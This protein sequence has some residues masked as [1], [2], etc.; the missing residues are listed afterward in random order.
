MS[1]ELAEYRERRR[2]FADCIGAAGMDAAIV[3]SRG[4][5]TLDRFANVLYLTGH[6]QSYA[7]LPETPGLFSGR[8]H[9]AVVVS[10]ADEAVLCVSVPEVATDRVAVDDVRYSEDFAVTIA[11]ACRDLGASAGRLA[12]VGYD[13][14]PAQMWLRLR[15]LLGF[16]VLHDLEEQLA[17]LRLIKSPAEQSLVRA[18]AAAGR[19]AV[20][21]FLN[22]IRPGTS[23]A[24]AVAAATSVAVAGGAGV[25]FAAVS[26]GPQSGHYSATPLPGYST[27]LLEH[28]DLVRVDLG[29]VLDGYLCD[30]GRT[31]VAGTPSREQDR[32]WGTLTDALDRVIDGLSPGMATA[33]LVAIGDRALASAGVGNGAAGPSGMYASYPAHWG[34]GLGLGWERPWLVS[35]E[36]LTLEP[37]MVLAVE[38]AI[39]LAGVGTVAAEQNVLL[40]EAGAEL[41]TAGPAGRWT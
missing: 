8:S 39:T 9:A 27:R 11:E 1:I 23:E 26:S 30:F 31:A 40:T 20:S 22:M 5:G 3:I 2:R 7:Y 17:A 10:A 19:R 28:G 14:M 25:Y 15:E 6:Y 29:I 16:E 41:L 36:P 18:A 12:I 24:E 32:L 35:S 21:A 33:D 34:H 37:G 13:V 38:R 4:G